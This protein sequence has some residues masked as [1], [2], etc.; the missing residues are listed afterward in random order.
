[1]CPKGVAASLLHLRHQHGWLPVKRERAAQDWDDVVRAPGLHL[2]A[3][4]VEFL[5]PVYVGNNLCLAG[6]DLQTFR[7]EA[8]AELVKHTL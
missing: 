3:G 6:V 1:M 8:A 2:V 5:C 4:D 7:W